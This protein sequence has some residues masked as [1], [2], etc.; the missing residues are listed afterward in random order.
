MMKDGIKTPEVSDL[1][2]RKVLAVAKSLAA[3]PITVSSCLV[4][5]VLSS[6]V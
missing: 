4:K 3:R 1:P 6:L 5:L 2:T